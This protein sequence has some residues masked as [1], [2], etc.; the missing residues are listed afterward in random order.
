MIGDSFVPRVRTAESTVCCCAAP[1]AA[2][3]PPPPAA[4]A[5]AAAV[6]PCSSTQV[7]A[8]V[9]IVAPSAPLQPQQQ[10]CQPQQQPAVMAF[11]AYPA[12]HGGAGQGNGVAVSAPQPLLY[13]AA[14]QP[15]LGASSP[16]PKPPGQDQ[17]QSP[18][19]VSLFVDAGVRGGG[20]GGAAAATSGS[21]AQGVP[22]GGPGDV[23]AAHPSVFAHWLVPEPET[24]HWA[25]WTSTFTLGADEAS[26]MHL[27]GTDKQH[28][29]TPSCEQTQDGAI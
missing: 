16:I 3:P 9:L 19:R 22:G 7:A 21:A 27:A 13:A 2:A 15:P 23:P 24:R 18:G 11:P 8:E 26:R 4:A 29:H 10:S 1:T 5:A 25:L 20:G 28:T 6:P 14:Q 12:I 17:P